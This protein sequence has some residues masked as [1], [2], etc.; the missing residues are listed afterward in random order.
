MSTIDISAVT[1]L[2]T[3]ICISSARSGT[4]LLRNW[5]EQQSDF[6]SLG[7]IMS[8]SH[9]F[10]DLLMDLSIISS[11]EDMAID[12]EGIVSLERHAF[13]ERKSLFF[14]IFYN[15]LKEKQCYAKLDEI[16]NQRKIIHLIR[17][18]PL[19]VY[20]SLMRAKKTKLWRIKANQ[21]AQD[22]VSIELDEA[23]FRKWLSVRNA[24]IAY[25]GDTL[26][27]NG[28]DHFEVLYDESEDFPDILNTVLNQKFDRAHKFKPK[29]R[30][31]NTQSLEGQIV[32]YHKFS[33]FDRDLVPEGLDCV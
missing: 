21:P 22:E 8:K 31:Q 11:K 3:V 2:T 17:P 13:S 28:G 33:D 20:F 23:H 30:K 18:N 1:D 19:R 14:K 15:H 6:L 26:R 24:D 25:V 29:I 4:N 5:F 16:I 7:E 12:E 27:R 10:S 9:G 32:N